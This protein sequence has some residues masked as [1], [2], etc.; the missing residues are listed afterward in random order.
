MYSIAT[1]NYQQLHKKQMAMGPWLAYQSWRNIIF[2]HWAFDPSSILPLI[3]THPGICLDTYEDKAWVSLLA[4][5]VS[6]ARLKGLPAIP[7]LSSFNELQLRTYIKDGNR[8]ATISLNVSV[9]HSLIYLLYKAMGI[10]AG[11]D[12][13]AHNCQNGVYNLHAHLKNRSLVDIKWELPEAD[14]IATPLESWLTER[15][16][17]CRSSGGQLYRHPVCHFPLSIK[18]LAILPE[19]V[20]CRLDNGT[21]LSKNNILLSHYSS[22]TDA[23]FVKKERM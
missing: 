12:R 14:H 13:L 20:Y 19:T 21:I 2:L 16:C 8:P 22:G 7:G 9:D 11:K 1:R 18:P 23:L 4:F 17:S 15:Y 10:P 6:G 5:E 3:P